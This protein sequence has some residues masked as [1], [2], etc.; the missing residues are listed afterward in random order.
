VDNSKA[1]RT[2]FNTL[3]EP[4]P[5]LSRPFKD[6]PA[7]GILRLCCQISAF[8][9]FGAVVVRY[10]RHGSTGFDGHIAMMDP[11]RPPAAVAG[12][13]RTANFPDMPNIGL[14]MNPMAS[15]RGCIRG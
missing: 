3:S 9:C 6:A 14:K 2:L 12:R 10:R 7:L 15:A 13:F 5:E 1:A 8:R 11:S 4:N